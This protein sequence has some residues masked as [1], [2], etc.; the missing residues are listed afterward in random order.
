MLRRAS[1]L[2]AALN[3]ACSAFAATPVPDP[4]RPPPAATIGAAP[5]PRVASSTAAAAARPRVTS[6]LLDRRGPSSAWINGQLVREG[7]RLASG[8]RLS[9]IDAQSVTLSS[10]S[11][12]QRLWL[13]SD[14]MTP[15]R[16][17]TTPVPIALPSGVD[18]A[19][20]STP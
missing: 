16:R 1:S 5:A 8:E 2:L 20:S 10:P 18:L 12:E 9:R 4:T 15:S 6:I 7:E 11:G 14:V 19:R 17:R 3:C 13:L